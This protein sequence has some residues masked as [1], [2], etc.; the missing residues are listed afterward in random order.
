MS[1]D[2]YNL[3]QKHFERNLNF[4][5]KDLLL[6]SNFTDVTLVSDDKMAFKAHKLVLSACSQVFRDLL[7]KH[8]QPDPIIYLRGIHSYEL[9]AILYFLYD[10]KTQLYQS[11]KRKLFEVGRKLQINQLSENNENKFFDDSFR[12]SESNFSKKLYSK[13]YKLDKRVDTEKVIVQQFGSETLVFNSVIPETDENI[14]KIYKCEECKA[15]FEYKT[16]LYSHKKSIHEGVRYSCEICNY[17]ATRL[18][19][20]K[21]HKE[22]IHHGVRYSCNSC[23]YKATDL[24]NLTKHKE[25]IHDGLRYSCDSCNYK[26]TQLNNLKAHKEAIHEGIRYSCNS[27]NYKATRLKL[28]KTHKESIHAKIRYPCHSC[29]YKATLLTSL[30]RHIKGKH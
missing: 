16:S 13:E 25:S 6:R 15:E 17:K 29:D 10:G 30:K 11:R 9:E 2:I 8:I 7:V 19:H 4:N 5:L 20:L 14:T 28:L 27:C 26:A 22:S 24:G 23:D 1:Q 21:R 18:G 12:E 3:K